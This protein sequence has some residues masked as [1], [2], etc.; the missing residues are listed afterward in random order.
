MSRPRSSKHKLQTAKQLIRPVTKIGVT[1]FKRFK[2]LKFKDDHTCNVSTEINGGIYFHTFN[3]G[4]LNT[5]KRNSCT[6]ASS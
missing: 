2:S 4:Q 3:P 5:T 6:C 1:R